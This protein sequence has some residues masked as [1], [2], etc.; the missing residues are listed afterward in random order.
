MS[1]PAMIKEII[2][3]VTIPV[4]RDARSL[5]RFA[6]LFHSHGCRT[7]LIFI[8]GDGQVPDWPLC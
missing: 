5:L 3:A 6:G 4:R 1:D 2:E 7:T 8:K